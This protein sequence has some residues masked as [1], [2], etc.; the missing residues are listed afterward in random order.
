MGKGTASKADLQIMLVWPELCLRGK[1]SCP[2]IDGTH[3]LPLGVGSCKCQLFRKLHANSPESPHLIISKTSEPK[4]F[5]Y[6]LIPHHAAHWC[7]QKKRVIQYFE[8]LPGET[9]EHTE[10][11]DRVE[12]CATRALIFV[13]HR[14]AGAGQL[15]EPGCTLGKTPCSAGGD[16][17]QRAYLCLTKQCPHLSPGRVRRNRQLVEVI[18]DAGNPVFTT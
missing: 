16:F 6:L 9:H 8:T 12:S 2:S 4:T 5:V 10:Y 14:P 11:S 17:N 18:S 3:F 13:A 15:C 1:D 7:S